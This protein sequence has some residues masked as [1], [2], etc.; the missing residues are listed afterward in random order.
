MASRLSLRF[1]MLLLTLIPL[2]SYLYFASQKVLA[3]YQ[4]KHDAE[5]VHL[6]LDAIPLS[7]SL[8]H[9]LQKERA[10]STLYVN[11][12]ISLEA[13]N[14]QR[15]KTDILRQKLTSLLQSDHEFGD[16]KITQQLSAEMTS[17]I[18]ARE[19]VLN[20]TPPPAVIA[21]FSKINS[22]LIKM[23]ANMAHMAAFED[24]NTKILLLTLLED[25]KENS[26][27]LRANII[28]VLNDNKPITSSDIA[29]IETYRSGLVTNLRSPAL[30]LSKNGLQKV[31]ALQNSKEWQQTLK[32]FETVIEK[33]SDGNY[34]IDP[35]E[36][37]K[38]I[39]VAIDHIKLILDEELQLLQTEIDF[40]YA[41]AHQNLLI[42][43]FAICLITLG[44]AW[45]SYYFSNH[46][47]RQ[48]SKVSQAAAST[49]THLRSCSEQTANSSSGLF[50]NIQRQA[51]AMQE[52]AASVEEI[53]TMVEKNS[54][55][56]ILCRNLSNEASMEVNRGKVAVKNVYESIVQLNDGQKEMVRQIEEGN[57]EVRRII[58]IIGEINE[59]TKVINDIVFQT[60][61]LSFN[62]SV[63]AARAG[64]QG[65]GFSV[66]AEEVGNLASMSGK[67]S[68][69]ISE[70]LADSQKKVEGIIQK[71]QTR[72]EQIFNETAE[73][74]EKSKQEAELSTKSFELISSKTTELT[75]IVA[76]ISLAS[77]EQ[78]RGVMQIAQAI[79]DIEVSTQETS[80][81]A[82]ESSQVS[83]TLLNQTQLNDENVMLLQQTICGNGQSCKD[84][85]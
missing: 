36:F 53:K 41:E 12:K 66:V 19:Q 21:A 48:F 70:L 9:E 83:K 68:H 73:K 60:R 55:S 51:S 47:L 5:L 32:T 85:A 6:I 40:K 30:N 64:D 2:L 65:K 16:F 46:L 27:L 4:K 39:T 25:G 34:G 20:K 45:L 11:E 1:K 57:E 62:A 58:G 35:K 43:S 14:E 78:A 75:N 44:L 17:L 23:E 29:R 74:L 72:I 76:E 13:L 82:A 77:Q 80:K 49:S 33:S 37:Y 38:S 31:D 26:G 10:Q 71:N 8:I 7:S 79:S 52:T 61:L 22:N 18:E 63:E 50:D 42:I 24:F 81:L 54:E 67:A 28:K 69:E 84:A 15:Q 3:N 59:K 56:T